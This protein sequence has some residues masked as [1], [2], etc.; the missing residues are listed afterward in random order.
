MTPRRWTAASL[1]DALHPGLPP[2]PRA[3]LIGI[4]A[5]ARCPEERLAWIRKQIAMPPGQEPVK[6]ARRGVW[7]WVKD[8]MRRMKKDC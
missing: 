6:V 5:R 4:L 2:V 3:E 1:V 7:G 8:F